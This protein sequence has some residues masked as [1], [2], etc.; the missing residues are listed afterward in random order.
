MIAPRKRLTRMLSPRKKFC[1]RVTRSPRRSDAGFDYEK[2]FVGERFSS[3][4]ADHRNGREPAF[5][6]RERVV[7]KKK[8]DALARDGR[9]RPH[10]DILADRARMRCLQQPR[11]CGDER[12]RFVVVSELHDVEVRALPR[13]MTR[14]RGRNELLC[15]S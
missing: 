5:S 2:A 9:T 15:Q 6:G 1:R 13:A 8:P 14:S 3:D 12:R 11:Q 10:F 7:A 4:G